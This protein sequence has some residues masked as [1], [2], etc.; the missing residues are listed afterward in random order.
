MQQF[1][2]SQLSLEGPSA[3]VRQMTKKTSYTFPLTAS[4]QTALTEHLR[5]GNYRPATVPYTIIAADASDCRISLYTSGKLVVQ[6]KGAE[7]WV[8]FTLEPQI[9]GEVKIGYDEVTSAEASQPHMG[10]DESGKGDF[11]GPLVI[12]SAYVDPALAERYRELNVRDSKSITSDKVSQT[13][14]GQIIKAS[15]GRFGF[16]SI[17]NGAYNRLYHSM[18]SV[19][20]ILAWGHARC[21]EDLLAKVPSCPRAISD[22]FGPT[23]QIE[24]ALMKKGRSIELIQR[25][26]AESD[27][28]VAAASILA[29]AGFLRGL[30]QLGEKYKQEFPKGASPQVIEAAVELVKKNGPKVLLDVAKCHF[31][32][33][34]VVLAKAGF[35]RADLGAEGSATSKPFTR[36]PKKKENELI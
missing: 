24:N 10:V 12:A 8:A 11:F 19:N 5:V 34:D 18:R 36:R 29:R 2:G 14:A 28:A 7:E 32:T 30:L 9:L 22:Q 17:G 33:A 35:S 31:K 26:K 20:L 3:S 13:I 21:I 27:P 6:G 15:G 23:K 16:V 1:C 25:T 4:Q